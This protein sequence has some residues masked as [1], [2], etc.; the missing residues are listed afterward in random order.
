[1]KY[2]PTKLLAALWIMTAVATGGLLAA[3][4]L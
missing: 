2:M 4:T 1:M 3:V